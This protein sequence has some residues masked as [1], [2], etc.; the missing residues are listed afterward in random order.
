[1]GK[2]KS[3]DLPKWLRATPLQ[4]PPVLV[5]LCCALEFALFLITFW[6][7]CCAAGLCFHI[8]EPSLSAHFILNRNVHIPPLV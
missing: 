3:K 7:P 4:S 6:P 2:A 5:Q 1:M 8:H